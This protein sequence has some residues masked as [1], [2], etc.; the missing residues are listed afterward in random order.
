MDDP[1]YIG[2]EALIELYHPHR[3]MYKTFGCVQKLSDSEKIVYQTGPLLGQHNQ[4][5][6]AKYM[7]YTHHDVAKLATEGVV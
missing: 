4:E 5:V 2:R 1:H 3:C 7:G 6:L